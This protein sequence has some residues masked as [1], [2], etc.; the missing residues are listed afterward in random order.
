[1]WCCEQHLKK[2]KDLAKIAKE[3]KK[4]EISCHFCNKK[5]NFNEEELM[6]LLAEAL[7]K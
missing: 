3:D 2:K 7:G 1:M 4:A 5:Y 6:E